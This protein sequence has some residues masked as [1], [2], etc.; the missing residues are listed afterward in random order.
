MN[1]HFRNRPL[2]AGNPLANVLVV[3]VGIIVIS[4]SVALGFVVFVGI[5]GFMLIMAAV[6]SVRVWWLKR[7][8]SSKAGEGARPP[9]GSDNTVRVIEGEYR[10]IRKSR[11]SDSND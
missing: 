8:F 2:P 4:L 6:V 1:Q 9:G 11:D 3:I 10:E 5:A 7:K